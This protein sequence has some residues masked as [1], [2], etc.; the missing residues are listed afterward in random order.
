[1]KGAVQGVATSTASTPDPKVPAAPASRCALASRPPSRVRRTP[2]SNTP[3]KFIPIATN[4]SAISATNGGDCS[5]NPQPA[6][7]PAARSASSIAPRT[8]NDTSTPAA[9]I[10]APRLDSSRCDCACLANPSTFSPITGNT[11]GIRFRIRPPMTL[12]TSATASVSD[13]AGSGDAE[14]P[15]PRKPLPAEDSP[16][17]NFDSPPLAAGPAPR[18]AC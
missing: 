18:T 3:A 5:W 13:P 17:R 14:P 6:A 12:K 8:Q 15:A 4:S 7:S 2:T 10:S 1:M 9:K 11:Q 16:D